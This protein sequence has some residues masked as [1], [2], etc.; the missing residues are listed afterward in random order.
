MSGGA[1]PYVTDTDPLVIGRLMIEPQ[2]WRN[3]AG[4]G[5]C[6]RTARAL[7]S[8]LLF[9]QH[10][11]AEHPVNRARRRRGA[12]PANAVVTQR[13]GRLKCVPTFRQRYGLRGLMLASGMVLPGL[14]TYIGMDAHDVGDSDQP[15]HDL[16]ARIRQ[17]RHSLSDYDFVHV[18]TKVPDEAAHSKDPRHK[19]RAIEAC[20]RGIGN[21]IEP[22]I[23]DPD[24]L[25]VVT[26]DHSTPSGGTTIHSGEAVPLLLHGTGVRRDRVDRFDEVAVS[27]GALSLV[28]G[29]ELLYMILDLMDRAKLWGLMDTPDDQAYWPGDYQ[30]FSADRT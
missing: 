24:V 27:E 7:K 25:L 1:S 15:E 5:D 17:A 9:A 22:L 18:H 28:R 26:A 2:G 14:A 11:L 29:R 21:A 13:A 20:D 19:L 23:N 30:P 16:A 12:P 10:A 4:D 3:P 6:H 8:Y